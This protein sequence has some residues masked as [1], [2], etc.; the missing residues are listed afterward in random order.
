MPWWLSGISFTMAAKTAFI[1][2][3]YNEIAYLHRIPHGAHGGECLLLRF[4]LNFERTLEVPEE[5]F[6]ALVR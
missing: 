5:C 2:V 3:T 6:C 1:F 4:E